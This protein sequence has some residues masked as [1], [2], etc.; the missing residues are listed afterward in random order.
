MLLLFIA[1]QLQVFTT[2]CRPHA[3]TPSRLPVRLSATGTD[4]SSIESE[5]E[6]AKAEL[7]AAKQEHRLL[8]RKKEEAYRYLIH[9]NEY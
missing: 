4:I 8:E 1:T 9:K 2:H 3:A 6:A 7:A 5:L